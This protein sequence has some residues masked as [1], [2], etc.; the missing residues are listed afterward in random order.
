MLSAT[1]DD[2]RI[3][4][5]LGCSDDN[6]LNYDPLAT[7]TMVVVVAFQ[8][9]QILLHLIIPL[10][11]LTMTLALVTFGCTDPSQYNYDE[12]ANTDD[13]SCIVC[14]CTDDSALI[15][16]LSNTDFNGLLCVPIIE[17][18]TDDSAFN[19][20]NANTDDGSCIEVVLGCT[21]S[22]AFNYNSLANTDDGSCIPFIMVV[23]TLM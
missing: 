14:H 4:V 20:F 17:G 3:E 10:L 8:V 21:D 6:A 22:T 19:Y 2:A 16:I 12:S 15:I 1:E 18:C 7:P 23:L 5:I 13:G 9:V 11:V